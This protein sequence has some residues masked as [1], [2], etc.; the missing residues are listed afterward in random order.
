[1]FQCLLEMR[2]AR[3]PATTRRLTHASTSGYLWPKVAGSPHPLLQHTRARA[4]RLPAPAILLA[5]R[6]L[7]QPHLRSLRRTGPAER[8]L[9]AN[10]TIGRPD[11][12]TV[13]FG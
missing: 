5:G 2:R 8:L 4:G 7:R 3:A 11:K 1:M 10:R 12:I 6:V 9:D 13:T